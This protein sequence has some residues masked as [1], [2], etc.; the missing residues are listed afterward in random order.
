MPSGS[1]RRTTGNDRSRAKAS[2]CQLCGS[3]FDVLAGSGSACAN[4]P[5]NLDCLT[6]SELTMCCLK[7]GGLGVRAARKSWLL[8]SCAGSSSRCPAQG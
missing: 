1:I 6:R 7:S 3:P 5:I 4:H 8:V 2:G